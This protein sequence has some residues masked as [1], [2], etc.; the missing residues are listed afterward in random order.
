MGVRSLKFEVSTL[1]GPPTALNSDPD[2][3]GLDVRTGL[4]RNRLPVA[5]RHVERIDD[6]TRG[7]RHPRRA[8]V[9]LAPVQRRRDP[10]EQP[11]RVVGAELD[12]GRVGRLVVEPRFG[13]LPDP[14]LVRSDL[15]RALD[16]ALGLAERLREKERSYARTAPIEVQLPTVH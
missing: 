10:A 8:D 13:R 6:G 11:D 2:E 14:V 15:A 12:N 3:F 1:R 9:E 4:R 16:G 5:R 7:G